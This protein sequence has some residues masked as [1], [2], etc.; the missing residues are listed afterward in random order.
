MQNKKLNR[1]RI[2]RAPGYA[3]IYLKTTYVLQ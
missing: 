3:T 2:W 1:Q